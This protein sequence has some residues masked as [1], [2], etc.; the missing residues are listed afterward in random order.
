L[1]WR[2]N[3][4][5]DWA[6]VSRLPV[7]CA[8]A[9]LFRRK[10]CHLPTTYPLLPTRRTTTLH[11][12][13]PPGIGFVPQKMSSASSADLCASAFYL[14]PCLG[15]PRVGKVPPSVPGLFNAEAQRSAE[16]AESHRLGF[17]R[18]LVAANGRARFICGPGLL[19]VPIWLRYAKP[20]AA[21]PSLPRTGVRF[22][23]LRLRTICAQTCTIAWRIHSGPRET[24]SFET[25]F[26]SCAFVCIRGQKL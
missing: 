19:S 15:E 6:D 23:D 7:A 8:H 4:K 3:M 12:S 2:A 5:A 22:F 26:Y 14:T 18:A 24:T 9:R 13:H 1:H 10:E 20:L 16:N 17:L 11:R 21:A 25:R